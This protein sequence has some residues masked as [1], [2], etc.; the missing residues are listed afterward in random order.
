MRGEDG[1]G[2]V[3]QDLGGPDRGGQVT[4]LRLQLGGQAAVEDERAL[5]EGLD[6]RA[7]RRLTHRAR[8]GASRGGVRGHHVPF[9]IICR[10]P[11]HLE[12]PMTPY[13]RPDHVI[14]RRSLLATAGLAAA[15]LG[16][17]SACGGGARRAR[18]RWLGRSGDRQDQRDQ[19][20]AAARSSPRAR[21]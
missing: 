2:V 12:P 15:A 5:G 20:R 18:L 17:L 4:P 3:G 21:P 19:G 7:R 14:T 10:T 9:V 13:V 11:T 6:E 8:V 16:G 1:V